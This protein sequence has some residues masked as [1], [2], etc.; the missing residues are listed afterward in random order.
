MAK[1]DYDVIVHQAPS[2]LYA[3]PKGGKDPS[4][5]ELQARFDEPFPL[6]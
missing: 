6:P 1:N 3:C 2:Y 5:E 4:T